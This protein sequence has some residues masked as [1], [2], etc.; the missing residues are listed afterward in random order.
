MSLQSWKSF[1]GINNME[2]SNNISVNALSANYFTLKTAYIGYFD[3]CGELQVTQNT[4]LD[5]NVII[6]GNIFVGFSAN[7]EGNAYV[8]K[9]MLVSKNVGVSGNV[10]ISGDTIMWGNLHIYQNYEIEK[11]LEIN[12]NLIQMGLLVRNPT[13]YDTNIYNIN[14][15]A[16]DKKLGLNNYNPTYSFDISRI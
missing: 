11:N 12:G 1:G 10:D 3:I 15:V 14:I 6:G 8:K 16:K 9:N 5:S 2:K 4:Y 7:I 13:E